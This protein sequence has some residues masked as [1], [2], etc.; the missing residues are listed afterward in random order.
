M[1]P[2]KLYVIGIGPGDPELITI[3]AHKILSN[4][5]CLIV[6]K[7]REEGSSLALSIASG[8]IDLSCKD[9][10]E[11][12]F[13]MLK[14]NTQKE[15]TSTE[16]D[17]KWDIAINTILNALNKWSTVAFITLGDPSIYSTF[18]YIYN[19]LLKKSPLIEV[20]IIPGISSF[21]ASSAYS[22]IPLILGNEKLAVVPATYEDEKI[23][24]IL[25]IF[26]T[27]IFMKVHKVFD[28]IIVL[29]KS[30]GLLDKAIYVSQVSMAGQK[31]IKNINDVKLTDLNYFSLIIVKKVNNND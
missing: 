23:S 19:G 14:T 21:S 24:Q 29:L 31:I 13:P 7:G 8:V 20:E 6:P 26:E 28:K 11:V 30:K 3:K 25:D 17:E 5:K 16:L 10:V 2:Q 18:F 4:T 27:I 15:E 22:S 9:I 1:N 12:H